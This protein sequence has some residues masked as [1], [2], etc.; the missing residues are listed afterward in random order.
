MTFFSCD[1]V[2]CD[3]H[4][5]VTTTR[6]EEVNIAINLASHLILRYRHLLCDGNKGKHAKTEPETYTL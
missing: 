1:L 3:L 5:I 4:H 2:S 6:Y